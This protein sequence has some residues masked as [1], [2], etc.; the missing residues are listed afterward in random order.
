[1]PSKIPSSAK[2]PQD[3]KTGRVTS[4][5]QATPPSEVSPLSDWKK[6]SEGGLLSFP[7][8]LVGRAKNPGMQ[9]FV[10]NGMIPN[11]L[12]PIVQQSLNPAAAKKAL[13][14]IS[15]NEE[16]LQDM[17]RLMDDVFIFCMIEPRVHSNLDG[18][19]DILTSD[20]RDP[21]LIYVDDVDEDDK[22]FFFQ[23]AVGG[24]AD[25]EEFRKNAKQSL[26]SISTGE[27]VAR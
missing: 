3:R 26:E 8:G 17:M 5:S 16:V 18:A 12:L 21:N 6:K 13:E 20:E 1:M 23:W 15:I 25:Y 27:D 4:R 14:N 24:T 22:Q 10:K 19:G 11:V 7:S 9:V 2:K